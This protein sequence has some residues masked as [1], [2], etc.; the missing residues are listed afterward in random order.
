MTDSQFVTQYPRLYH[1]AH[2][3]AWPLIRRRGLLSTTAILDHCRISGPAR[4]LIERQKRQDIIIL[5]SPLGE[6]FAIRDQKPVNMNS[7]ATCLGGI[8]PHDW[9]RFL[10]GKVFFWPNR[11]RLNAL[12]QA[13]AYRRTRH[14]VI[15]VDS[16][17]LLCLHSQSITLCRINSGSTIYRPTPR[18]FAD[19]KSINAYPTNARGKA[20]VAEV[21]VDYSVPNILAV[22][23]QATIEGNSESNHTV[24]P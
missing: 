11:D 18:T 15:E 9:L 3:D 7:L 13:R 21:A 4:D 20:L 6:H 23:I 5:K 2:C 16:A 8:D 24:W 12:L 17:K 10:N 14:C 1:M 22:A 19:F